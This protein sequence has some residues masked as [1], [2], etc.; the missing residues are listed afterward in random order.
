MKNNLKFLK[1]FLQGL[2]FFG[3]L[4]IPNIVQ[5]QSYSLNLSDTSTYTY[6]NS[7]SEVNPAQWKVSNDSCWLKT[8]LIEML[9]TGKVPVFNRINLSGNL[10]CDDNAYIQYSID[11]GEFFNDTVINGCDYSAVFDYYDTL[12]LSAGQTLQ[13]KVICETNAASENWQIKGGGITVNEGGI[14]PIELLE[15]TAKIQNNCV[16]I[17]WSTA[18]E[19]NNDYFNIEKSQD[20]K[21][22]EVI[23]S[24]NGSETSN[25]QHDYSFIDEN[26]VKGTAYYR[27]KQ[28]DYD[29][30]Y[31]Y[32]YIVAVL[33]INNKDTECK[34]NVY[35]N[36]CIGKCIFLLENCENVKF[37]I[38]DALGN[39]VYSFEPKE[40]D[41]G[42][43]SFTFNVQGNLKPG[44]YIV[45]GL[46]TRVHTKKIIIK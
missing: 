15:F 26:P 19:I 38:F 43:G 29:G 31:E 21:N 34:L 20:G 46:D 32:S 42:S 33:Y 7:C 37:S 28:T 17:K 8:S 30:K 1:Y 35:P 41:K 39:V 27:L 18:S 24:I 6:G 36:P 12:N 13:I 2:I 22:F 40:L 23:G 3:F 25:I 16:L 44:M 9:E 14:L 11:R 45:R 10:E 5:C 4:F